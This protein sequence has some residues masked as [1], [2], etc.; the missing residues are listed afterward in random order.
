M[1]SSGDVLTREAQDYKRFASAMGFDADTLGRE[2]TWGGDAYTIAGL[3]IK[4]TKYPLLCRRVKDGKMYKF[5]RHVYDLAVKPLQ[6]V[7]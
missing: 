5:P 2:L 7:R 4:S 3:S 1:T 6:P